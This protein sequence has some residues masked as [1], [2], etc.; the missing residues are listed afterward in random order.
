METRSRRFLMTLWDGGGNAPPELTIA[1]RLVARGHEVHV[2]GDPTLAGAAA[3]VGCSF[4]PWSRAP[5]RSTHDLSDDP[6]TDWEIEDPLDVLRRLRDQLMSGAASDF[7]AETTI[8]MNAFR[9]D[10]LLPD[11]QLFGSIIA[12]EAAGLPVAVLN[13]NLWMVPTP[14]VGDAAVL[15]LVTRV[16]NGGLPEL[17][18]AR[19]EYGLEP[20]SSFYDQ[21]LGADRILVLSSETFDASAAFVPDNVRYVGPVLDDP[22]WIAPWKS[23]WPESN[24]SPLIL[25]GFSSVYQNHGPLM[26]RVIDALATMEVRAL[27]PLGQMLQSSELVAADNVVVVPSAPYSVVLE[28]AAV[29]VSHCG[30]GTTMKALAAGVPMVCIP[31]G[32]DQDATAARVLEQG[33]GIS[34]S[35]SAS[36]DEI[37]A[38]IAAVLANDDY[39]A[40]AVRMSSVIANEHRPIDVVLELEGLIGLDA[41]DAD[42]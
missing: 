19:A 41:T 4:S 31:L 18:A 24:T 7:A 21:I 1:R 13:P 26:Q 25:V 38:A 36:S 29:V 8:A 30:H 16:V 2:L 34:L 35:P 11:A 15:R 37:R 22:T 17:N 39:R 12:A 27:V 42:F 3:A 9:P 10:A 28:S 5:N 23:P 33:A 14:G 40:N 32:R 6:L 20:L